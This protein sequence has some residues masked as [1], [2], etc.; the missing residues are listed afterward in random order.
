M[1]F[2]FFVPT[3]SRP[4]CFLFLRFFVDLSSPCGE[5][6]EGSYPLGGDEGLLKLLIETGRAIWNWRFMME[7]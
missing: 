3:V 4:P 6:L 2:E 1:V 5:E 7:R